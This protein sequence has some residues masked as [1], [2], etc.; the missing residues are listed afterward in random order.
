MNKTLKVMNEDF[1]GLCFVNLVDFDMVYGHR[2]NV[3]GYAQAMSEFDVQLETFLSKM[4]AEDV[5]M[6]TADHGCDPAAPG[7]DHT[8][9]YVPLIIYGSQIKP[10]QNM[11][12][13]P[14]FSVISAAIADFFELDNFNKLAKI[15]I[16]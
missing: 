1:N 15:K 11:G 9:E 2:R 16:M 8:R 7:T 4:R 12:T 10:N 14:T 6:I 5:L 3:D 13:Y